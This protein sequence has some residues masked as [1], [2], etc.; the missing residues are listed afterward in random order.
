MVIMVLFILLLQCYYMYCNLSHYIIIAIVRNNHRKFLG[1]MRRDMS[2]AMPG[3]EQR[4]AS[5]LASSTRRRQ[6]MFHK[7]GLYLER[8]ERFSW[9]ALI[10][11][12]SKINIKN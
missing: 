9:R 5:P 11:T 12:I 8:L 10:I 3:A 6:S 4:H 1:A 7:L 2:A